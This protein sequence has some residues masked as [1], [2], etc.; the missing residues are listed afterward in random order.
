MTQ[1]THNISR[2]AAL[3]K[4]KNASRALYAMAIL[5][6]FLG[7]VS[8]LFAQT[9]SESALL[10]LV[11]GLFGSVYLGLGLLIKRKSKAALIVAVVLSSLTFLSGV[12]SIFQGG[13]VGGIF[14][15]MAVLSQ[16]EPGFK[17]MEQLK[18]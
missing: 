11:L 1:Q 3:K 12:V 8:A 13:S 17:A 14:L 15:P 6:F 9:A 4:L 10:L 2:A 5:C 7:I 16:L 18:R